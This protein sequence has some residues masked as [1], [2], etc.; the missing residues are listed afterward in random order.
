[1]EGWY[2]CRHNSALWSQISPQIFNAV[3]DTL[4]WILQQHG[5]WHYLDDYITAGAPG[6]DECHWNC[7][8]ITSMCELLGVPGR[9][10]ASEKCEGPQTCLEYLGFE[11][12]TIK[13]EIRL[14]EEKLQRLKTLFQLRKGV[15]IYIGKTR[16]DICPVAAVLSFLAIRGQ[17]PGPLFVCCDSTPCTKGHFILKLRSALQAAGLV[18]PNFAGHSF[19]IRA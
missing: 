16:D 18:G 17:K 5:V 9:P 10:L 3:A 12:D 2:L 13:G 6:S 4:E 19:C 8:I 14:P 11:L 1:M 7:Q 15:D